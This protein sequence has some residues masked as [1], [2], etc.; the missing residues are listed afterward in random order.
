MTHPLKSPSEEGDNRG[1]YKLPDF[2]TLLSFDIN[3]GIN[4]K[5][6]FE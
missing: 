4:S 3:L 5:I 6:L 2:I 1:V